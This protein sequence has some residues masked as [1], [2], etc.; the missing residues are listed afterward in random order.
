MILPNKE[1]I[2]NIYD[3]KCAALH[4]P[5]EWE[6][7]LKRVSNFW[8]V[9]FTEALLLTEQKPD[10]TICGTVQQWKNVGRTVRNNE[11]SAALFSKRTDTE[12]TYVFDIT[13][14]EGKPFNEKWV[15]SEN[16][17]DGLVGLFNDK[18]REI[19]ASFE[20]YLQ[21]SLDK[22]INIVYNYHSKSISGGFININ[23][24]QFIRESADREVSI[25]R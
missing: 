8:R 17:A 5:Q 19:Y 25:P 21:K 15:M 2:E 14:T 23:E 24:A 7:S 16:L 4:D 10:A 13:Q 22:E 3:R 12:L 6:R 20:D 18:N 1:E 9:S 11:R